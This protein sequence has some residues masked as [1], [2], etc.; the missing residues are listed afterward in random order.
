V[1]ATPTEAT[2]AAKPGASVKADEN[3]FSLRGAGDPPA[4]VLKFG[5]TLQV[6]GRAYFDDRQKD[7]ILLRR[8]R[9]ILAGT[10]IGLVDFY[11]M[12]DFGGGQVVLFDSYLDAH[13]F[14]WLRL[15]AGKFK[16]PI[17][18]ER[19][20]SD[21][22]LPLPERALTSNLSP[23]RDVGAEV[24][25]EIADGIVTYA[26]AVLDG[27]PDNGNFD[28]DVG[29]N[30]DLAGRLFI[31]PLKRAPELGVLGVGLAAT[32]GGRN[33]SAKATSLAPFKSVGQ[34]A[35]FSYLAP[36]ADAMGTSTVFA[37]GRESRV[38]PELYYYYAGFGLMAEAIWTRQE[39]HKGSE[40]GTLVHRAGHATASYVI[41]GRN[42]FNGP[43]P[44]DAW[45]PEAGHYGALEIAARYSAIEFASITFPDFADPAA[46]A[47]RASNFGAALTWVLSRMAQI[48]VNLEHTELRGASKT[49][50]RKA[51]NL[52]LSRAQ[53]NF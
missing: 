19:L 15:R 48:G 45:N 6:D 36:T 23:V 40:R 9:P 41:G 21:A 27:S 31:Q 3:G 51:E 13:P 10:L 4:F 2:P 35:L 11:V 52:L 22:D 24:W 20:Q 39:L 14:P 8:V 28:L 50:N 37:S 26:L 16:A 44:D 38:N 5:A 46:S 47:R 33:G 18:L 12:P 29:G 49:G 42:G 25:G 32:T 53:L 17:G 43:T 30:K 34:T 1:T 7:N